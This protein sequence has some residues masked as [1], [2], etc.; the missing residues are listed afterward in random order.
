MRRFRPS[1]LVA[2]AL[3]ALAAAA[4]SAAP[5]AISYRTL[6]QDPGPARTLDLS[7]D[8]RA[9]ALMN[10]TPK[11]E[12][13]RFTFRDFNSQPITDALIAAHRREVDVRGV[14]D[15]GE[16]NQA[17]VAQLVREIGADRVVVC[18]ERGVFNSCISI[19]DPPSLMHN[20]FMTFSRLADG[21]GPIV[22]Q[23]SKNFLAPSQLTYYNDMVEI[24]GDVPLHDAYNRYFDAL[25]AQVRSADFYLFAPEAGPNTIFTSPRSQRS[26]ETEDT[27]VE[28]MD[29]IDCSEGGSASG[30]GLIRVANMAFRSE[31]AVIMTRLVALHREGCE[32][33]VI[34][35]N[36]DGD[37][38]AGLASEGIRVRPFFLRGLSTAQRQVIVHS[39]FWLVDAVSRLTGRRAKVV[40]AGSSNW[41]GDQQRSDDLLLRIADD[42]VYAAYAGYWEKIR[43]RVASDQATPAD[44]TTAP[45]SALR[46]LPAPNPAGWNR[47][48]VALRIAASDGHNVGNSGLKSLHVELSGLQTGSW[49]L[50][51]E[52]DAHRL[53]ELVVSA[54]GTTTVRYRAEDRFGNLEPVH[55]DVVRIDRTLPRI[56][57]L[58]ATCLLWP[59]DHR[60]VHVADVTASD[61]D[62]SG[63]AA[64]TPAATGGDV[65][66]EGGSIS[67]RAEKSERGRA[68]AYTLTATATDIA[69]NSADAAAECL[70]PH[71]QGED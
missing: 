32:I 38:V 31:R 6:F 40:Y 70:V 48:D 59:P 5:A 68:R 21:R 2:A 19:A 62:G 27:I 28:R 71:S 44:D 49:E 8:N 66:V 51:G 57:G 14:I 3:L 16:R 30:R 24:E 11:G 43:G 35:T 64:L 7:L 22:L 25:Q 61:G 47:D 39:K 4:P 41:R 9:I 13:L 53:A 65:I 60:I 69:G 1:L 12:Q 56:S 54:E 17:T 29:E 26:R 37:I 45:V 63:V 46:R 34:A 67:V 42:G 20:K 58:P 23:T 18:G 50:T 33:D 10:A 36:L 15:G 52:Q 55:T